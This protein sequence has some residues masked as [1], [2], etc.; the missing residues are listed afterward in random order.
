MAYGGLNANMIVDKALVVVFAIIGLVVVIKTIVAIT[1]TLLTAFTCLSTTEGLSF[2]DFYAAGGVA[3]LIYGVM[4]LA[5]VIIGLAGLI[6]H[7]S[8]K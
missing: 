6:R 2:S 5:L 8:N 4:I 1:P 7:R 3:N